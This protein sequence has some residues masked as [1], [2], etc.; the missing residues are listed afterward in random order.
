MAASSI[1]FDTPRP[2]RLGTSG[3]GILTG[4]F[5]DASVTYA[6]ALA[7]VSGHF[8]TSPPPRINYIANGGV[9][10]YTFIAVGRVV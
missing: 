8:Q 7:V 4:T 6:D 5:V 3:M 2:S 10:Q 9:N 1:V